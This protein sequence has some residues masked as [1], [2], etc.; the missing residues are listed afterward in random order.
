MGREGVAAAV[1]VADGGGGLVFGSLVVLGEPVL[2]AVVDGEAGEGEQAGQGGDGQSDHRPGGRSPGGRH[3]SLLPGRVGL[4]P[5]GEVAGA[6][7][8]E[9]RMG[10]HDARDP[11]VPG[12][13]LADLVLVQAGELFAL[14]IVLLDL[15]PHPGLD[16]R[17]GGRRADRGV[18][19]EVGVLEAAPPARELL[20]MGGA[21]D[22]QLVLES[23]GR[24]LAPDLNGEPGPVVLPLPFRALPAGAAFPLVT[25]LGSGTFTSVRGMF[26]GPFA[27]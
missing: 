23:V 27:A 17:V 22:Q 2:V 6:L 10:E 7:D 13:P 1:V 3:G 21:A 24:L 14:F 15:P 18:D 20:L 8:G 16:D 19:E 4:F 5:R 9:E 12:R 25:A 26:R 11:A